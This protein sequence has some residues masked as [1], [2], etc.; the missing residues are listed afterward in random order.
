MLL[1]LLHPTREMQTPIASNVWMASLLGILTER[2]PTRIKFGHNESLFTSSLPFVN[3][4]YQKP[5]QTRPEK[6][7]FSEVYPKKSFSS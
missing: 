5:A 1:M 7:S 2:Q 3:K 4:S 6:R